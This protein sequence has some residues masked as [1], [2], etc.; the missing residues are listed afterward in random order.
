MSNNL[1]KSNSYDKLNVISVNTQ[2]LNTNTLL[3]N[4]S[5]SNLIIPIKIGDKFECNEYIAYKI[6]EL[7][8]FEE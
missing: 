6:N 8:K 4:N 5:L 3:Y 2:Y 7:G 1:I